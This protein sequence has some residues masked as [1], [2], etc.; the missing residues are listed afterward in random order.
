MG[1]T[2][3]ETA[4]V[5][6]W[7]AGTIRCPHQV[8]LPFH[9]GQTVYFPK[10]TCQDCPLWERCTIRDRAAELINELGCIASVAITAL[11]LARWERLVRKVLKVSYAFERNV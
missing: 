9:S 3:P 1:I 11:V 4:F 8:V 6:N 5:L 7:E 10:E 2:T